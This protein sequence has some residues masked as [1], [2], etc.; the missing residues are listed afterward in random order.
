ML[1]EKIEQVIKEM[2]GEM[3]T[4]LQNLIRIP[5]ENPPGDYEKIANFLADELISLGFETEI[6]DVPDEVT[7]AAGLE[8]QRKNVIARLKGTGEGPDL[9][10]NGHIDTVPVGDLNKWT[11]PPFSGEIV[12]GKVYG[13]GATDSK[14]RLV[15]YI[16]AALALKKLNIPLKGDVI[17]AA[18]CDEETGGHLGAGYV[19]ENGLLKG[20]Y[21]VV[22][23]YSDTIIRAMAGL[24]QLKIVSKGVPA[25]SGWKWKGINAIEKMAKVISALEGLQK[26]LERETSSINGMRY[27][28]LNI[29]VIKGGTKV[30]VVPDYCEVEVDFRVIPEHTLEEIADRVRKVIDKLRQED[31]EINIEVTKLNNFITKPTVTSENSPLVQELQK[32]IKEFTGQ[33]YPV[34]GVN[35]Q[36]DCRW[37]VDNGV[38]GIN[39]GPGRNDFNVHGYDEFMEIK[40]LLQTACILTLFARNIVS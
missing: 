13:R 26:E 20:D 38:Q 34:I 37:F 31:P 9:I 7:K 8:G 15:C 24:F 39:F 1:K 18:T 40:D 3:I 32:A 19:M 36:S 29:G 23:G 4:L 27:T 21:A 12:D 10:F 35:G 6:I 28:T 22:E 5:S 16:M 33:T 2:E 11:Y 30:N 14:G 25:H 17:I